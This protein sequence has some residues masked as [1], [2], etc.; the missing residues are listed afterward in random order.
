PS[1]IAS[2]A[3]PG[4][5]A[6]LRLVAYTSAGNIANSRPNT[7]VPG[8]IQALHPTYGSNGP[9]YSIRNVAMRRPGVVCRNNTSQAPSVPATTTNAVAAAA[10]PSRESRETA[11]RRTNNA[12]DR[13]NAAYPPPSFRHLSADRL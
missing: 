1:A 9:Q 4:A 12:S 10:R 3:A 2:S 6:A 13:Q 5:N 8:S 7:S 11:A